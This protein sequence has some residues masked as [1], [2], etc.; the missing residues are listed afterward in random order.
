MPEP[1]LDMA[2]TYKAPLGP[3]EGSITGVAVI[4]ISGVTWPHPRASLVVSPERKRDTG[5]IEG[6]HA[7][8]LGRHIQNVVG[9]LAGN[10]H[11]GK[12]K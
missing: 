3:R 12:I 11:T 1:S 8:M 9:A 7:V 4:P 10:R 5:S 6:V 2:I